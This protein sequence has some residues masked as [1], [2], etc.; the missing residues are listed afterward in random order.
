MNSCGQEDLGFY[1]FIV[2][3]KFRHL[4]TESSHSFGPES[5]QYTIWGLS[6]VMFWRE[7]QCAS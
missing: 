1:T 5:S 4:T 6:R 2:K 7:R 3:G